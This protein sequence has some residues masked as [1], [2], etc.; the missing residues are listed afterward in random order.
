MAA[1]SPPAAASRPPL[2]RKTRFSDA[3]SGAAAVEFAL[4]AAPFL[5]LLFAM[6]EVAAVFF[7]STVLENAVLVAARDVR[8]GVFQGGGGAANDFRNTVCAEI[9]VIGDCDELE[10]DIRVFDGFVSVDQS[11]MLVAGEIDTNSLQFDPGGAG[12]IVLVRLFYKWPL[13]IPNFGLGLVNMKDN[14]RLIMA[15]TVFRNEPFEE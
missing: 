7:A 3:R 13:V 10:I 5:V 6:I 12:D 8:T 14:S 11:S 15:T 4:I 1:A 9:D 2:R